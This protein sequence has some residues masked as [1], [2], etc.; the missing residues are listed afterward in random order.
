[1]GYKRDAIIVALGLL[2]LGSSIAR[3]IPHLD[4]THLAAVS[5]VIVVGRMGSI[6]QVG[7]TQIDDGRHKVLCRAM[8]SELSVDQVLQGPQIAARISVQFIIPTSF[9]GYA[10]PLEGAYRTF[11]LKQT[12]DSYGFASPH[13]ASVPAIPGALSQGETVRDRLVFQLA[14][15]LDSPVAPTELKLEAVYALHSVLDEAATRALNAAAA[16]PDQRVRLAAVA[17]L[18]LRGDTTQFSAAVENLLRP[19]PGASQE[20]IH[21]LAYAI[22]AGIKDPR[23]IPDLMKL[24]VSADPITRRA[25]V[26]ALNRTGSPDSEPGLVRA[27]D[28]SDFE[29]R[30]LAVFGLSLLAKDSDWSPDQETY[31]DREREYLDHWKH[32]ASEHS[33]VSGNSMAPAP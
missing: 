15:V 1:M 23:L 17:A 11:F 29:N 31:R 20:S 7:I 30:F 5:D 28:D 14:A 6:R 26:N 10:N 9:M 21:N 3:P 12:V 22:G 19:E 33:R 2:W 25:S 24:Q 8:Q 16:A 4:L 32:W 18:L 13:H 27:L